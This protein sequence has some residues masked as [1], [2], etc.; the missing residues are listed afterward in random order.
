MLRQKPTTQSRAVLLSAAS[1]S[2]LGK[3]K[4]KTSSVHILVGIIAILFFLGGE[5]KGFSDYWFA[6]II[7]ILLL[8]VG[9]EVYCCAMNEA[10]SRW[11]VNPAILTS[12]SMFGIVYGV[13]NIHNF[14]TRGEEEIAFF[15]LDYQ[16]LIC[17]EALALM[18]VLWMWLGYRSRVGAKIAQW[19]REL[20]RFDLLLRRSWQVNWPIVWSCI[21]ASV[22]SRVAQ[23]HLGLYGYNLDL[24]ELVENASY[25]QW[26][27]AIGNLG[28]LALLVLALHCFGPKK[29]TPLAW[30]VMCGALLCELAF[31]FLSGMKSQI[32]VPAL[33]VVISYYTI[34]GKVPFVWSVVALVS[35]FPAFLIMDALRTA[36]HYDP[37]YDNRDLFSIAHAVIK[38]YE[39]S[40]DDS[41]GRRDDGTEL[42]IGSSFLRRLNVT[43]MSAIAIRY[44]NSTELN[45]DSPGSLTNLLLQPVYAIIPRFL[46]PE[47]PIN[48]I[49]NWFANEVLGEGTLTNSVAMGPVGQLYVAGGIIAVCLGFFAVGIVQQLVYQAFWD[50]C[51]GSHLMVYLAIV[52]DIAHFE[53]RI[54]S[55]YISIIQL[56]PLLLVCQYF[57]FKRS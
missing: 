49:G 32:I 52:C 54:E 48:R 19:L 28:K 51:S 5:L 40:S 10:G 17:A 1:L 56:V 34:K 27:S 14:T 50:P 31:G 38:S 53:G 6:V 33:V 37:T 23:I 25:A 2:V 7:L 12:L 26:L 20:F 39:E 3:T 11:L 46:W 44:K 36:R 13:S 41:A 43:Q 16:W 35:V 30:L 57:L 4:M 42:Q 47:K 55:V 45:E 18:S 22:A 21:F 8:Y 29:T 15:E 9:Y 24:D